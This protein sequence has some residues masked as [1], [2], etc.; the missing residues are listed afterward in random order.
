M[1]AFAHQHHAEKRVKTEFPTRLINEHDS[2]PPRK[3][4]R[5]WLVQS[6]EARRRGRFSATGCCGL[7]DVPHAQRRAGAARRKDSDPRARQHGRATRGGAFA[8]TSRR[9]PTCADSGEAK[10]ASGHEEK[11][12]WRWRACA[13]ASHASARV[14]QWNDARARR[15]RRSQCSRAHRHIALITP[16][17]VTLRR[18]PRLPAKCAVQQALR[19]LSSLCVAGKTETVRRIPSSPPRRYWW[20]AASC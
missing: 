14:S 18:M 3:R 11:G 15:L 13:L 7:A 12:A 5:Q 19:K 1:R 10:T 16:C 6:D 8:A 9:R 17:R 4:L 20:K 2:I